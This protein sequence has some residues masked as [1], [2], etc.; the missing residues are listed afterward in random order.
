MRIG[1]IVKEKGTGSV[2]LITEA[3]IDE[4]DGT[5]VIVEFLGGSQGSY[6]EVYWS[7]GRYNKTSNLEVLR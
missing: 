6:Q 5:A 2:G 7:S 1:N 3:W 4:A